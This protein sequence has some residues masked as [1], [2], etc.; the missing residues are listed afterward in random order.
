VR[1]RLTAGEAEN[2]ENYGNP[3]LLCAMPDSG[4]GTALA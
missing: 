1:R 4:A 3:S 2:D